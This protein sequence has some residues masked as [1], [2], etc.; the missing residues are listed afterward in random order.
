[1]LKT[2]FIDSTQ[3]DYTSAELS[4]LQSLFLEEG[5]LGDSA[6]TLGLQ[7]TQNSPTAMT[8]LVSAGN[9][10]VELTKSSVTWKVVVQSNAQATVTVPANSSGSNRVDAVIVRVDK[11]AEPNA[12]KNNI[13]TIE[14]VQGSGA[15]A[16]TDGAI[17]TAVGSD[18]WIRLADIT[19]ANAAS[20]IVTGNIADKRAQ[21][22]TNDSVRPATKKLTFITVASDPTGTNLVEGLLWFN[23]TNHTL[24]YYDGSIV[25]SVITGLLSTSGTAISGSNKI[26]DNADTTV[27][28][29]KTATTLAFVSGSPATITDSGSGFITAGFKSG[30]SITIS[31]SASNNKTTTI[32]S[33]VSGT[34]TLTSGETLVNESAG[35][36]VTIAASKTSKIVRTDANGKLPPLDASLLK[37][38]PFAGIFKNGTTTRN[39]TGSQTIAHGVGSTP[40]Y[41]RITCFG[42]GNYYRSSVGVYN[43]TTTSGIY[44]NS[45]GGM[46]EWTGNSTNI[47]EIKFDNSNAAT[48]TASFDGTNITL[49]WSGSFN[50]TIQILW[51]AFS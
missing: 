41:I 1:M 44:S 17:D 16:L 29:T 19:V 2:F 36:S 48:A 30:D 4:W 23:S 13:A 22:K 35:A 11:D 42:P 15:S 33:V 28:A 50:G 10:L 51:E 32:D 26:V 40:K 5:V 45:S 20:S 34:I 46:T 43:G 7:V 3:A 25:Q 37:N 18:G 24:K 38:L 9:A 31:G 27:A 6:G 21:V 49:T 14:L 47:A 39:S 12:L 8:V